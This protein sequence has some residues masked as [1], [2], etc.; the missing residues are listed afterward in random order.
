M[1]DTVTAR[2]GD[3]VVGVERAVDRRD[4]IAV[5]E[6]EIRVEEVVLRRREELAAVGEAT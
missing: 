5:G 4:P 1:V 2:G 6:T 3:V